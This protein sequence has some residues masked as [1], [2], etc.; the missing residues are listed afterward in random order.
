MKIIPNYRIFCNASLKDDEI[1][2][3]NLF[4]YVL[5]R[6]LE[7]FIRNKQLEFVKI[8]NQSGFA[9]SNPPFKIN[10]KKR[11]WG[12]NIKKGKRLSKITYDVKM[13]ALPIRLIEAIILH[14]LV[15]WISPKSQWQILWMRF[16]YNARL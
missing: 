14:E 11:A 9:L 1:K 2:R 8:M 7:E 3:K 10:L 12:T 6:I 13:I 4:I 15:H 16:I 5:S